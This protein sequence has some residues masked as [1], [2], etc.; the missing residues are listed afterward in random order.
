MDHLTYPGLQAEQKW[1]YGPKMLIFQV[2]KRGFFSSLFFWE[3]HLLLIN[4]LPGY[5]LE[6][7]PTVEHMTP[8]TFS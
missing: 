5:V 4:I 2:S 8:V 3:E 1:D 7:A 6:S